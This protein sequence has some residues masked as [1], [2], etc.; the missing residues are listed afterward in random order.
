M[1]FLRCC[2]TFEYDNSVPEN[3]VDA[4]RDLF[5][6]TSLT[7]S[8]KTKNGPQDQD[9]IPM[10]QSLDVMQAGEN[11]L[12]I[13]TLICCQNPALNPM[14]LPLAVAT[15]LP[16]FAPDFSK[17]CRLEIYDKQEKVFR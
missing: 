12:K 6:R 3:S 9:I 15:Y 17:C 7:V 1:A 13:D 4:I 10:I 5:A 11:V 16:E 8:K 14:Q 2:I